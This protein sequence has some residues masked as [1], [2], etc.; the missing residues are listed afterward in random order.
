MNKTIIFDFGN[1]LI[2]FDPKIMTSAYL[3]DETDVTLVSEVLFDRLYWNRLDDGTITDE[4]VKCAACE[5]LPERL[6]HVTCQIYDKWYHHLPEMEGMRNLLQELKGKGTPL[7]L[8]SNISTGFEQHYHEVPSLCSLL[9]LF[10]G[11]VFS[12]SLHL[13]KPDAKIFHYLLEQYHLTAEKCLFID[14]SEINVTGAREAGI[15]AYRFDGNVLAL[16]RLLLP[17]TLAESE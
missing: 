11:C 12:G 6:H 3:S 2:R 9:S 5:R 7:Y 14:D 4:E 17:D 16:R 13:V 1:V 8:L 15:A 10:D